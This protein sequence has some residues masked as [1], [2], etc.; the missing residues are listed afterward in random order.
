[1]P[2][3]KH[4]P[5][6][7]NGRRRI[8]LVAVYAAAVALGY[9]LGLGGLLPYGSLKASTSTPPARVGW[10]LQKAEPHGDAAGWAA[11]RGDVEA[12]RANFGSPERDV[13]D[14]VA[15]LRGLANGG[16]PDLARAGEICRTLKWPRC[17]EPALQAVLKRS[18]P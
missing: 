1:M 9:G 15:A 8:A 2:E 5:E 14:L 16:Q 3:A 6:G 4:Q 11:L 7:A 13:F 10:V 12:V 17:D 18:R